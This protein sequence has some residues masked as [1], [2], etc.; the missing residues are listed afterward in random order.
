[1]Q[2]DF[3]PLRELLGT[4]RLPYIKKITEYADF[5]YEEIKGRGNGILE[6]AWKILQKW[7]NLSTLT[8]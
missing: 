3:Q 6:N 7:I 5:G 4:M 2:T 1:M 8:K